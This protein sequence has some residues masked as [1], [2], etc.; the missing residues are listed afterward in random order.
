MLGRGLVHPVDFQHS[1]NPPSQP[2]LLDLLAAE[3]RNAKYDIKW[4]LRE[5][6]LTRSYQRSCQL[7]SPDRIQIDHA[8]SRL[9]QLESEQVK[10]KAAQD[11][12]A[13]E[14]DQLT[15]ALD[16][17]KK[18]PKTPDDELARLDGLVKESLA[19]RD[20]AAREAQVAKAAASAKEDTLKLFNAAAAANQAVIDKLP[21][22]AK[23][24]SDK[25]VVDA[26]RQI[27]E[28]ANQ[29]R[30]ET[31]QAKQQ[32]EAFAKAAQ[33]A[34]AK[35]TQAE[36]ALA[37]AKN[38]TPPV[39]E[40][41][42]LQAALQLAS[43]RL[44][45]AKVF[46]KTAD[47]RIADAKA[48]IDFARL[49][50]NDRPA[51][52]RAWGNLVE[53]WTSRG[54]VATLKPLAPE[55]FGLSLMQATGQLSAQTS[56]NLAAIEKTPPEALQKAADAEKDAVKVRLVEQKTYDGARG[57]L[58]SIVT[59]YG[60]QPGQDFAATLNQALFF[61]NGPLVSAWLNPQAGYLVERLNKQTDSQ[62]FAEDLYLSVFTRRPSERETAEIAEY[63]KDR[64]GD[65]L[66][67]IQEVVWA[68]LSSNEFRFNH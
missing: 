64:Q 25:F 61:G 65:R 58:A 57:S 48:L 9:A 29:V 63:L 3:F 41:E 36:Q 10:F 45:D 47:A 52:E 6:A 38:P 8:A 46:A 28:R 31:G 1:D 21:P 14:V 35:A 22:E 11:A 66:V 18:P 23:A 32:A 39:A 13:A 30:L 68:L 42:K 40:V 54:Y 56:A 62:A 7:P 60:G 19:A 44:A 16:V 2:E 5:L 37:A 67:A 15:K 27:V 51:A 43:N 34:L 4:L 33:E 26:A 20:K 12:A 53:S 17:L 59:L 55:Q 50:E 24:T 49:A